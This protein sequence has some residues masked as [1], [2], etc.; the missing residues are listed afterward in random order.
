MRGHR[1]SRSRPSGHRVARE[2]QLVTVF[3]HQ[4]VLDVAATNL[5]PFRV[6]GYMGG[7]DAADELDR[8]GNCSSEVWERL[9]R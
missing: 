1:V 6:Q 7:R 8:L 9:M 5:R 4:T 3:Q 2:G